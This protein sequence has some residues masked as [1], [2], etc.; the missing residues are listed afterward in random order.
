MKQVAGIV[1]ILLGMLCALPVLFVSWIERDADV[2]CAERAP[3]GVPD[4]SFASAAGDWSW[5][6][7]V[8]LTCRYPAVGKF[9]GLTVAPPEDLTVVVVV[10]FLTAVAGVVLIVAGLVSAVR[11]ASRP[12]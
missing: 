1:L 4:A 12:L 2:T 5:V 6:S 8:G 7:P 11:R 9:P 10:A 3:N